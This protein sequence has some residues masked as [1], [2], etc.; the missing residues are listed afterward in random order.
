LEG[1][2]FIN[3]FYPHFSQSVIEPVFLISRDFGAPDLLGHDCL[4]RP[5]IPAF[6]PGAGPFLDDKRIKG[7]E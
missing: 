6:I 3:L 5:D 7:T 1:F 4:F 2:Y